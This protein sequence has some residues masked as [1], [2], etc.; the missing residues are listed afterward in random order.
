VI[1]EQRIGYY[2]LASTE[3]LSGVAGF[4]R[5]VRH[6]DFLAIDAATEDFEIKGVIGK[7]LRCATAFIGTSRQLRACLS[8]GLAVEILL[9][10]LFCQ[11]ATGCAA[12]QLHQLV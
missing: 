9:P 7:M 11:V 12:G 4:N 5:R 10:F 8:I 1:G 2:S 3:V 6:L